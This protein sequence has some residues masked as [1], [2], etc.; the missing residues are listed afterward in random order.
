MS[1]Q[2]HSALIRAAL[3]AGVRREHIRLIDT[4]DRFRMDMDALRQQVSEDQANGLHV[5]AVCANAGTTS[6]GSIDPLV[7]LS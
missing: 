6:T 5:V 1:N 2:S 3:I 7:A 4:D